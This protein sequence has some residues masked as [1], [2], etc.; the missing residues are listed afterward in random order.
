MF[1]FLGTLHLPQPSQALPLQHRPLVV[2]SAIWNHLM[3]GR[4]IQ[5]PSTQQ[6]VTIRGHP[7]MRLL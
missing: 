5:T 3:A 4:E 1:K 7:S 6:T 2:A